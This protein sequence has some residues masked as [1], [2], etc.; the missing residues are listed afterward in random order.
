MTL[1]KRVQDQPYYA[2]LFTK[3]F[4]NSTINSNTISKALSQFV[5]SIVSYQ[6]KYDQGRQTLPTA[7]APPPN[8][9][10]PNFT[11][12]ENR[13]KEIFP[14]TYWWMCTLSRFRNIYS[15]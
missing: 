9:V 1:V 3:A 15:T 14:F 6:S 12:Q 5:R 10:F 8:A 4:G 7:P 11:A 2:S 13:G